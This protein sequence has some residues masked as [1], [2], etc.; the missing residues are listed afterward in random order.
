M[1]YTV[2]FRGADF[3]IPAK[4]VSAAIKAINMAQHRSSPFEDLCDAFLF[5]G[6]KI[7]LDY[8]FN[9]CAIEAADGPIDLGDAG[10]IMLNAI[11]P[12]V[13]KGSYIEYEGGDGIYRRHFDGKKMHILEGE[14]IFPDPPKKRKKS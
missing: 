6:F 8:G 3:F 13:R 4:K 7:D 9:V 2:D 12:F 5:H 10:E 11:A 1:G 14:V